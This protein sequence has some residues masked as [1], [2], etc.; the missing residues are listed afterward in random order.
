LKARKMKNP[1]N[2]ADKTQHIRLEFFMDPDIPASKNLRHFVIFKD[3]CAE[4]WTKWLID[5]REFE[6]LM[7]IRE[8]ADKCKMLRTL[9]K[10]Y[11]LSYFEHHLM[12][13]LYAEDGELPGNDLIELVFC[14]VGLEYIT[15]SAIRFQK[16]YMRR[17]IFLVQ[18]VSV[19]MFVERLNE[20]N[21]NLIYFSE[22][23]PKKLDQDEII[24]TLDQAKAPEG[25]AAM[26]AANID[27]SLM[28]YEESVSYFKRLENLKKIKRTNRVAVTSPVENKKNVAS[29]SVGVAVGK[30]ESKM[31]CHYCDKKYH[32]TANCREIAKDKQRK[33]DHFE[34]K[35]VPGKKSLAF[36]FKEINS[37]KKQ[38]N[39]TKTPNPKKRTI[40]TIRSNEINLTNT[41]DEDEDYFPFFLVSIELDLVN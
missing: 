22:E 25:H 4:D 35:A 28:S 33:S 8:P 10:G 41:S 5:Y 39:T 24:K 26:V 6:K 34:A 18:N 13:R 32:N 15:K 16:Y 37:L 3:G 38:L 27:L 17:E 9:L 40:E 11:S 23:C 30:K 7:P 20:L 2:T 14:D 29:C 31:W 1:D 19:L 12:K 36:L 21:R